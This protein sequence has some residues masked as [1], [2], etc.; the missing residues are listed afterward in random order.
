VVCPAGSSPT[1]ASPPR[2][3]AAATRQPLT[4][5]T[6]KGVNYG[7]PAAADGRYLG[8]RWLRPG[9][10][11]WASARLSLAADLDFVAANDLGRV[12]RVFIGLD[13]AMVWDPGQGFVRFDPAA[14]ANFDE[15]LG[16]FAARGVKMIVV[17]FDQEEVSSPGNFHPQ[18]LDGHHPAMRQNYLRAVDLFMARFGTSPVVVAWDLFN[19]AYGSL[20]RAGLPTPPA[21]D[22]TSPNYPDGV[23]HAWIHDLYVHA[24][25]AAPAAWLTVSDTTDIY[26]RRAVDLSRYDDSVD[27]YD[28]HIYDDHPVRVAWAGVLRKP[29]II[30][31]VAADVE[32][33]HF[34][35]QRINSRAV[36]FWLCTGRAEGALAVLAHDDGGAVFPANR[37]GLTPTGWVLAAA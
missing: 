35:N 33:Q 15:A 9:P 19:E 32:G 36:S 29:L 31:E 25:C 27:Y 2:L 23:V 13:Q 5:P 7:T 4:L 37:S 22:P 24:A 20:G 1:L 30:G 18:A 12:L 34:L 11:G 21:P 8:T 16:M 17:L 6:S 14:L 28:V 3:Q 26:W 10:G